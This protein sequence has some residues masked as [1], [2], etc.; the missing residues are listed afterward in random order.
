MAKQR[1]I[2]RGI[3]SMKHRK[4]THLS[5]VDVEMIVHEKGECILTIKECYYEEGADVSGKKTNA[6]IVEF[7]EDVKP[8]VINSGNRKIVAEII[9]KKTG[10]TP[11]DSRNIANWAG[12]IVELIFDPTVKFGRDVVGG[13]KLKKESPIPNIS[14]EN[15]KKVLSSSKELKDL[16]SNWSKLSKAEQSLPSVVALK[17]SLK[18]TLK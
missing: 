8:M 18:N 11:K 15:A 16:A 2:E 5:G 3:D 14:D 9:R 6:Y 13:I 17:D 7:K 10:C 1:I 12:Q 4:H